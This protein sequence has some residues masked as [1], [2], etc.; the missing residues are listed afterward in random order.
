MGP[1][2][3]HVHWS[4]EAG[5]G[6]SG[7]VSAREGDTELCLTA[8][9][10]SALT[11]GL[12]AACLV[13]PAECGV[14]CSAL[15]LAGSCIEFG[16]YWLKVR[17]ADLFEMRSWKKSPSVVIWP[18]GSMWTCQNKYIYI[19]A[20][21]IPNTASPRAEHRPWHIV[22]P[23]ESVA[24]QKAEALNNTTLSCGG[25]CVVHQSEAYVFWILAQERYLA[26]LHG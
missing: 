4:L 7:I 14:H 18:E 8:P 9:S 5:D 22:Q 10:P 24:W 20:L 16:F 1:S 25:L 17:E 11:I 6:D 12:Y 23:A 15:F 19:Y 2:Q 21:I 3:K 13:T 26:V